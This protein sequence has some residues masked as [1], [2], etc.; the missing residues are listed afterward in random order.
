MEYKC[1]N[2]LKTRGS[3]IH[4][5]DIIDKKLYKT[6]DWFE[7]G[8]F[9]EFDEGLDEAERTLRVEVE[10]Q[11]HMRDVL[12]Q[13]KTET[14]PEPLPEM[15]S[16]T[17]TVAGQQPVATPLIQE[18]SLPEAPLTHNSDFVDYICERLEGHDY[19]EDEGTDVNG[20]Y[21][22][23]IYGLPD[24][25]FNGQTVVLHGRAAMYLN[26]QWKMYHLNELEPNPPYIHLNE[27]FPIDIKNNEL[28]NYPIINT[29]ED[30]IVYSKFPE[31]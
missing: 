26:N 9:E 7:K 28:E 23:N 29:E 2:E 5:D 8:H 15:H 20:I 16:F 25:E 13:F 1:V 11:E 22:Y 21:Q 3:T 18:Q 10:Y 30:G 31:L 24:A 12:K 27:D 17:V 6:L 4:L 19:D 14:T